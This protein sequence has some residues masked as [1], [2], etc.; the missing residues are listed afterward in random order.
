MSV[1]VSVSVSVTVFA[2]CVCAPCLC[3]S[4]VYLCDDM[5]LQVDTDACALCA[6]N[7]SNPRQG[8]LCSHRSCLWHAL[9]G[10]A[11]G[12]VTGWTLRYAPDTHTHTHTRDDVFTYVLPVGFCVSLCGS[13]VTM[14]A[15][16]AR[17][18][19]CVSEILKGH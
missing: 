14:V 19:L 9:V 2:V 6:Y 16:H 10:G 18:R 15:M 8:P 13:S 4:G 5:C 11:R 12:F 3:A 7:T 17:G 1:S